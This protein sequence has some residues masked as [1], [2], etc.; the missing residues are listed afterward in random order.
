MH[1]V[2]ILV[3]SE[4]E[5]RSEVSEEEFVLWVLLD[6]SKDWGI[7]SLDVLLSL[8]RNCVVGLSSSEDV[9][10]GLLRSR[11]S[12]EILVIDVIWDLDSRDIDL[13][14]CGDH[15]RLSDSAEWESVDLVWSSDE[16]KSGLWKLLQEDHT[17]SL[18]TS[19]KNDQ[20]GSWSEGLAEWDRL[21]VSKSKLGSV[22]L[23][24]W[25]LSVLGVGELWLLL[26]LLQTKAGG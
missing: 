11:L 22:S 15:E 12:L 7:N 3:L 25:K 24:T 18:M 1:L 21:G 13:K 17:L 8:L 16:E 10:S 19:G 23:K 9:L 26:S 20:D 14:G 6:G 4:R 2:W 5:S